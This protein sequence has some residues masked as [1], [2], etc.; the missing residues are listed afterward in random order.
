[1]SVLVD[2]PATRGG[3]LLAISERLPR[4]DESSGSARF[5]AVLTALA[6][7]TEVAL[8]VERDERQ[9]RTP[10]PAGRIVE[11]HRRLTARGIRVVP[12]T[13][14]GFLEAVD[15]TPDIVLF[16]GYEAAAR[17]L[18]VAHDRCPA[19]AL[20]VD[21]VDVHFARFEA[22]AAIGAVRS[23]HARRVRRAETAVYRDAHLVITA[24]ADDGR[25]LAQEPGMPPTVCVPNCVTPRQRDPRAREP[26]AVFVG[27]FHHAPNLDGLHW[28]VHAG[29]PRVRARHPE[30]RLTVIGSYADDGVRAL[31][32]VPG[33]SV[34]GYV[35]DLTPHLD[36]AAASIAPLRYGAGMKGKVTDAMA[37]GLPVVT[38]TV[39]AQGLTG[40]DARHL[41]VA[42]TAEG[43]A[44][45]LADVFADPSAAA[46]M[47]LAGQAFIGAVC[48]PEAIDAAL[49]TVLATARRTATARTPASG[50]ARHLRL[51]RVAVR[52]WSWTFARRNARW[53]ATRSSSMLDGGTRS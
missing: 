38:T 40:A 19:A 51:A 12:S 23:S 42:D 52:H 8:W 26:E 48:G 7:M 41:R 11:D 32:R 17:Y 36:R 47:G 10:L 16:E 27:H 15:A 33:V 24:S 13:W 21:S 28:F 9:G 31:G 37:A 18:A 53:L 14:S 1:M 45:A 6:G 46:S 22:G 43:L 44:D 2:A 34:L 39:G 20:I 35:A 29:W 5:L 30:A 3:R 4:P 25:L 50:M 49:R